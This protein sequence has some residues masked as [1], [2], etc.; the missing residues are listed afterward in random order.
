MDE[1]NRTAH[2][3]YAHSFLGR[4]DATGLKYHLEYP[5]G[6]FEKMWL[7]QTP[8]ADMIDIRLIAQNETFD[9]KNNPNLQAEIA[10]IRQQEKK[11]EAFIEQ[12][13]A[14]GEAY[15]KKHEQWEWQDRQKATAPVPFL[16]CASNEYII[17]NPFPS[18]FPSHPE[19]DWWKRVTSNIREEWKRRAG[20]VPQQLKDSGMPLPL[21]AMVEGRINQLDLEITNYLKLAGLKYV[22]TKGKLEK[23]AL[24]LRRILGQVGA[25]IDRLIATFK[26]LQ[27]E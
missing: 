4:E 15:K 27:Q 19:Y 10:K 25:R 5:D 3:A 7:N 26:A 1:S 20:L 2:P 16:D 17:D 13:K 12:Q 8:D 24:E 21:Q 11:D 6:N 14:A 23:E 22:T 18:P 9:L